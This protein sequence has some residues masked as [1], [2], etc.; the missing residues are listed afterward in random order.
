[1]NTQ[2]PTIDR[3]TF[4]QLFGVGS[5]A[6][7]LTGCVLPIQ[8]TSTQGVTSM[9]TEKNQATLRRFVEEFWNKG[10]RAVVDEVFA[11]DFQDR[12]PFAGVTP[13]RE[14]LKQ[15][16]VAYRNAFAD[17]SLTIDDLIAAGD[18]VVWRWT[19]RG[20]HSGEL[21][22]IPATGKTLTLTGITIERFAAGQIVERWSQLD[23]MGFMQQLGLIS[24]Q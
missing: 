21:I 17:Q 24:G 11:A 13:D 7:T 5:V 12:N 6:F 15:A 1:M 8:P 16:I 19:H 14:G 9:S 4:L 23:M 18:K 10:N 22:G 3:R 20:V 2:R